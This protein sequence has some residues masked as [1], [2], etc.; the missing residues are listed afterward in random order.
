M[1]AVHSR[2]EIATAQ[3]GRYLGQLCKH[4]QH[5]IPVTLEA[6]RGHITFGKG[7]CR[8][9]AADGVLT[10][11]VAAADAAALAEVQDVVARHLVRFAFREP[12]DVAWR[13]A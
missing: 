8:L 3:A 4:F 7:D 2:A 13:A 9:L 5:K 10:L 6:D 12:L 11:E 1:S